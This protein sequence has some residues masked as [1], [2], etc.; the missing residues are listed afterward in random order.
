MRAKEV[1]QKSC[2]EVEKRKAAERCHQIFEWVGV[3]GK[4]REREMSRKKRQFMYPQ[5]RKEEETCE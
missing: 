3:A 2:K 5:V 4:G 1:K